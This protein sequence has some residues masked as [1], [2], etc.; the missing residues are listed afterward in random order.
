MP[1]RTFRA[2]TPLQALLLEQALLLAKQLEQTAD[3]APDGQVL[4]RVEQAALPAGREF[5]R[6]AVE[7]ALQQQAEAAEKRGRRAAPAPAA[8]ASGTRGGPPAP[9]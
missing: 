9:S 7:A 3:A 1:P 5:L 6:R 8:A 2:Q 4:T